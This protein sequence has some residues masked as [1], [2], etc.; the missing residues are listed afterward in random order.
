M[1]APGRAQGR[2]PMVDEFDTLPQWTADA[3]R[4]VGPGAAVPA[5]CRGSGS[6][7]ALRWLGRTMGLHDGV[8][9]LD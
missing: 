6:P 2:E 7:E 5:G 8:R 1:T 3:V 9:L 4:E